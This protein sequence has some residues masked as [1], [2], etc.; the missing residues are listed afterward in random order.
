MQI[1]TSRHVCLVW[2][3]FAKLSAAVQNWHASFAA[4]QGLRWPCYAIYFGH[5]D[6]L[7]R[8]NS[9]HTAHLWVRYVPQATPLYGDLQRLVLVFAGG[10]A[11]AA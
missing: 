8:V 7:G 1:S 4:P 5:N 2:S 11:V 3:S 10:L 6:Q 9:L